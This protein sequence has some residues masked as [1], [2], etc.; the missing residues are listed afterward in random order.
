MGEPTKMKRTYK[1]PH[2]E[3]TV[4]GSDQQVYCRQC[5][6]LIYSVEETTKQEMS[7][8]YDKQQ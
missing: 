7:L 4:N 8:N 3:F 2:E 6:S 5:K 1:C